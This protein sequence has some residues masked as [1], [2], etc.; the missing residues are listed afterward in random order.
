[1]RDVRVMCGCLVVAS[2]VMSGGFP[3]VCGR[4]LVVLRGPIVMLGCLL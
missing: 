2:L 1:L 4:L 3:M